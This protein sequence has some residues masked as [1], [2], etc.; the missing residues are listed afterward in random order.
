MDYHRVTTHH[1]LWAVPGLV[2]SDLSVLSCV[3]IQLISPLVTGM[4]DCEI[5]LLSLPI[6]TGHSHRDGYRQPSQAF[7]TPF[8]SVI[9]G[10]N[11]Y[12]V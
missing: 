8:S 12:R 2:H 9:S 11:Y 4:Q 10:F 6:Q 5:I 7:I 3:V 1:P